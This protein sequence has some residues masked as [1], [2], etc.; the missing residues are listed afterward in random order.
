MAEIFVT[1][2]QRREIVVTVTGS[3]L[4]AFPGDMNGPVTLTAKSSAAGANNIEMTY[5]SEA[6]VQAA[7]ADW[8]AVDASLTGV[9]TTRVAYALTAAQ[10]YP[11][12][13]RVTRA[14]GNFE[15]AVQGIRA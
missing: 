11:T 9:G 13:F 7:T 2:L 5:S 1:G 14:A 10:G 3:E 6:D 12:A 4:L 8:V 15:F